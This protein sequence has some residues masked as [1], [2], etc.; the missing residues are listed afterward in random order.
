MRN[1]NISETM[2]RTRFVEIIKFQR[3]DCKQTRFH[4]LATNKLALT[5]TVWDTFV[6]NFLR[7]YRPGTNITVDVQLFPTKARCTV[8]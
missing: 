4:R 6:G 3:F 7:H 5:S 2:A 1:S 8:E